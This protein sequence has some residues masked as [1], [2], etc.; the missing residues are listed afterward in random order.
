MERE[1]LFLNIG[2]M[3]AP[4]VENLQGFGIDERR[5]IHVTEF[6]A[7]SNGLTHHEER[8][9]PMHKSLNSEE[10]IR[11][12][13]RISRIGRIYTDPCA[14][15]SSAQSVFYRNPSMIDD[16]IKPQGNKATVVFQTGFT[17]ST[18]W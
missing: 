1:N 4:V 12:G 8:K 6:A 3:K 15:V 18:G 17:G 7:Q 9:A 11:T 13:T 10:I 5:Y 14:S 2:A 16:D